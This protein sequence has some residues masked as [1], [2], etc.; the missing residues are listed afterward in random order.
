MWKEAAPEDRKPFEDQ[1]AENKK[2]YD[3]AISKHA[4]LVS[5]WDLDAAALRAA[6]ER[7]HPISDNEESPSTAD[8]ELQQKNR[9]TR[10]FSYAE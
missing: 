2:I 5:K 9:R 1:A 7:D 4:E 3:E 6:Y 8:A 10:P